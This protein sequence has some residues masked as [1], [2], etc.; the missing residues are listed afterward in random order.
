MLRWFD[1]VADEVGW[2][3]PAS[4]YLAL[5]FHDAV[6]DPA[7]TDDPRAGREVLPVCNVTGT[8]SLVEMIQ[9]AGTR[10]MRGGWSDVT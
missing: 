7:R 8:A 5:V 2:R 4:V 3:D 1:V 6:D 9:G 10:T